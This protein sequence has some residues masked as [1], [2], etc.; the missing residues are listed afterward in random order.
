MVKLV[1]RAKV[2][3]STTGTGTITL[4]AAV[5]GF[6]TFADAGISN[7]Q[8]VRYT[9]EDGNDFE[10]GSGTYTAS[11]T[12]LTR[13]VDESTNSD[14]ALNLSG[15]AIVFITAA[16]TDLQKAA[17]M[18]QGVA[19]TDD[20]DFASVQLTGGT[21]T[22]GTLSW[23]SDEE[24]LDL[25][26][27]VTT[28]QIGQG[29]IWNVRNNSGSSIAKGAAVMATGTIGSSG[30]IT[31]S[32]MDGTDASNA[33][34]LLGLAAETI[35]NGDDGKVVHFGKVRGIDTS[36]FSE[37]DVLYVSTSTAGAL[38][39]TEPTSGLNMPI[40]FVV[41]DSA[42]V[43]ALAVRVMTFDVNAFAT[44]AQG[45]LADTAVQPNDS[46]TFGSITVT[47]TV[48]GRDVATDG[49]KL[50]GIEANATADQTAAEIKTAY[51]SNSDTNAFTDAEQTKLS[52]IE[53]SADVTDTANVTAAGALMD[54][55]VTN[56]AAVKAFDP[57]DYATAAQGTLA[58][59]AIQ[60]NDSP[61]FGDVTATSF[62][63]DGSSLTNLPPS[64][65]GGIAM[66]IAL[67]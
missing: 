48:D 20:V 53:A 37:G 61:T 57:A 16:S 42:S 66:A 44:S 24:T 12:T 58:D 32:L 15:D 22:Q 40:A 18:D 67:G 62:S 49:T 25:V 26:E 14:A 21:G 47:G 52:G 6:Q 54:S 8:S 38:T 45:D 50:D 31:V 10:I 63:G 17:D 23:N 60:P 1:N 2:L 35:A 13:S 5:D 33:K 64:G 41:T 7:G 3:T 36:A 19:T 56:L 65:D 29:T 51:E 55:E 39:A 9:I 59:S 4:G 27:G 34:F 43:G 28:L 30:R 11:G 46:P